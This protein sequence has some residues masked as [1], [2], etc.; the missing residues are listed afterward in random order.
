[1]QKYIKSAKNKNIILLHSMKSLTESLYTKSFLKFSNKE[2]H[3]IVTKEIS[4]IKHSI[5]FQSLFS[6]SEPSIFFIGSPV[7]KV[8]KELGYW[9]QIY[10]R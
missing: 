2:F 3:E 10:N 4:V 5:K 7:R 9:L 1:M 6:V 8:Q